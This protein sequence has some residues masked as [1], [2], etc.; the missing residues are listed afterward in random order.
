[1]FPFTKD[2]QS[3]SAECVDGAVSSDIRPLAPFV[4]VPLIV[5]GVLLG[6]GVL[7]VSE[8]TAFALLLLSVGLWWLEQSIE[9]HMGC[10]NSQ[11]TPSCLSKDMPAKAVAVIPDGG[12]AFAAE[13]FSFSFSEN[14]SPFATNYPR[15]PLTL[16]MGCDAGQCVELTTDCKGSGESV[17][18]CVAGA[19]TTWTQ[20][21]DLF[22]AVAVIVIAVLLMVRSILRAK[23][24]KDRVGIDS[25]GLLQ[26]HV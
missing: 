16:L 20:P 5:L 21:V 8:Q 18:Q 17:A 7:K 9:I 2:A 1:L 4:Y 25:D 6:Y 11:V 12:F 23:V 15:N 14:L 3:F 22:F 26:R 13:G 10:D 19:P 24:A